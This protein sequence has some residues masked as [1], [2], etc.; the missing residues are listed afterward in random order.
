MNEPSK[1][2]RPESWNLA[3]RR[4]LVT[5]G[6]RGIGAAVA[7]CLAE[8]GA[9]VV[10]TARSAPERALP[11]NVSFVEADVASHGA[12]A[13]VAEAIERVLGGIDIVVHGV[14]A[15]FTRAGGALGLHDEDW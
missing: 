15:S 13:I 3:G 9:R 11:S 4:A 14:G 2:L 8:R 1:T 12:A 7:A 10:V 6:T 5:G